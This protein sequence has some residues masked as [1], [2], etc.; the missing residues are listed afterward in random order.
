MQDW[1]LA[2]G[3][4]RTSSWKE[5]AWPYHRRDDNGMPRAYAKQFL[6]LSRASLEMVPTL[7][8]RRELE[9]GNVEHDGDSGEDDEDGRVDDEGVSYE[10]DRHR[11]EG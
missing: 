3:S 7:A 9:A 1:I 11:R 8:L 5:L 2:D 4:A 10:L 6:V